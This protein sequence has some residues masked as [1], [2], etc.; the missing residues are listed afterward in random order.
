MNNMVPKHLL[1]DILDIA[2]EAEYDSS[3]GLCLY[4]G[5]ATSPLYNAHHL[6]SCKWLQ[7]IN[8]VE[9]LLTTESNTIL[10]PKE[11]TF[12][13]PFNTNLEKIQAAINRAINNLL[14]DER[15]LDTT[16]EDLHFDSMDSAEFIM[17]LENDF[18]IEYT[19]DEVVRME[20]TV[21]LKNLA[22]LIVLIHNE[23]NSS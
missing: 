11:E 3:T 15:S 9:E 10:Q 12:K 21:T 8:A 5:E 23:R 16:I 4:C 20:K 1:Q 7:T 22:E 13:G 19:D 2:H 18:N 14:N 17:Y 6:P